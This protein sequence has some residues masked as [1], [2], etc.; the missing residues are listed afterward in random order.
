MERALV[1]GRY[2]Y[3]PPPPGPFAEFTALSTS[4]NVVPEFR[5]ADKKRAILAA[6][7]HLINH[8]AA[9]VAE[10]G[11]PY[12]DHCE[13]AVFGRHPLVTAWLETESANDTVFQ[14]RNANGQL[15][16][17]LREAQDREVP[18]PCD[19]PGTFRCTRCDLP[20]ET[21][22]EKGRT[23]RLANAVTCPLCPDDAWLCC[24]C[25]PHSGWVDVGGSSVCPRCA[26]KPG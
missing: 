14:L 12:V 1:S 26:Y 23:V 13:A 24:S 6:V 3:I 4:A 19:R 16:V 11:Q 25:L 21:T 2:P 15:L 22:T 18:Q 7:K 17:Q 8:R 20:V 9:L 5:A 10:Y